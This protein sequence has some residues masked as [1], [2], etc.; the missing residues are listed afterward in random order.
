MRDLQDN[1]TRD[2][3]PQ[4]F[5]HGGARPNSGRP[6]APYKTKTLRVDT[7]LLKLIET[8][9]TRLING[10]IDEDELKVFEDLAA[11]N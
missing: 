10:A 1:Q 7:R 4:K 11:S 2:L 5:K 8:L 6:A 9:K 3:M